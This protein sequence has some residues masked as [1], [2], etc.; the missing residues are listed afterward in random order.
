LKIAG[1]VYHYY[2]CRY[3]LL[4]MQA[5]AVGTRRPFT[6]LHAL[7]TRRWLNKVIRL[8]YCILFIIFYHTPA[9]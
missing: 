7:A 5:A 8:F 9:C 3:S 1:T 2:C 4:N 6:T